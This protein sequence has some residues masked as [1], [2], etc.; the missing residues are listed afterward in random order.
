MSRRQWFVASRRRCRPVPNDSGPLASGQRCSLPP[1][2]K[3]K[4]LVTCSD[5]QE[6]LASCLKGG[7]FEWTNLKCGR[8]YLGQIKKIKSSHL[9]WVSCSEKEFVHS[10]IDLNTVWTLTCG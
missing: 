7:N 6:R 1:Q 9:W 8:G 4:F 5:A 10:D 2:K 3:C